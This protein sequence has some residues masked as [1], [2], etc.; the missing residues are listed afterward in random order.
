[1]NNAIDNFLYQFGSIEAIDAPSGKSATYHI[2]NKLEEAYSEELSNDEIRKMFY[3]FYCYETCLQHLKKRELHTSEML[4]GKIVALDRNFDSRIKA[5]MEL[6]FWAMSAYRQH[7]QGNLDV[8]LQELD[9]AIQHCEEQAKLFPLIVS[10][11]QEQWLNRLRVQFRKKDL[12]AARIEAESLFC[13]TFTGIRKPGKEYITTAL[14]ALQPDDQRTMLWHIFRQMLMELQRP[15]VFSSSE[16]DTFMRLLCASIYEK[17]AAPAI[18]KDGFDIV[19]LLHTYYHGSP[20]EFI[21]MLNDCFDSFR[22]AAKNVQK[23]VIR[24]FLDLLLQY[25]YDITKH[26][27]YEMFCNTLEKKLGVSPTAITAPTV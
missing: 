2:Y 4:F 13:F 14:L 18:N 5:G 27:N 23:L 12:E 21:G 25:E 9:T 6:I 20:V 3:H 17:I 8:A 1:M 16:Q 26:N 7:V 10:S 22:Q 11:I 15:G 19:M 24:C